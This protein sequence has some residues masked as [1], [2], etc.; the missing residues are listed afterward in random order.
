MTRL[1]DRM[2]SYGRYHRDRRNRLTHFVGVPL[3]VFSVLVL[4]SLSRVTLGG[5]E[6]AVAWPALLILI[7]YYATLDAGLAAALAGVTLPM[8][9]VA[10]LV[11]GEG[12]ATAYKTFLAGFLIGWAFQ[13]LGHRMEG[14]RPA[15]LDNLYQIVAAPIFLAGEVAFAL[16]FKQQLRREVAER[17]AE[18][19]EQP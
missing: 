17:I 12:P 16:G 2:A 19:A 10:G 5:T 7:G 15:L 3:I 8:A 1:A 9:W 11:A 4:L 6:L 13:L 14:N 18:P